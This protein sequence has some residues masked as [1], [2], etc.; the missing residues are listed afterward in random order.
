ME[1]HN[2]NN[3]IKSYRQVSNVSHTLVGNN[4]VNHSDVVGTSFVGAAPTTASVS[5]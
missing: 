1:Y 5:T 3:L 4:I 2:T